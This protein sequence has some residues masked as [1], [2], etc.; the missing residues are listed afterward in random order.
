MLKYELISTVPSLFRFDMRNLADYRNSCENDVIA[1]FKS[2]VLSREPLSSLIN[3]RPGIYMNEFDLMDTDPGVALGEFGLE[4]VDSDS[5]LTLAR[6][7]FFVTDNSMVITHTPQGVARSFLSSKLRNRLIRSNYRDDL[8]REM[9]SVASQLELSQIRG[10][11]ANH[12]MTES[13]NLHN[14]RFTP[15]FARK[16]IDDVFIMFGFEKSFDGD[17]YLQLNN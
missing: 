3:M 9:L 12:H 13:G 1:R 6:C 16:N 10:I 14:L 11:S 15:D 17:F 4:F 2:R 7:G 8:M 5:K